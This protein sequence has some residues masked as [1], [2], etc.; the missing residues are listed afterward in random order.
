VVGPRINDPKITANGQYKSSQNSR[1]MILFTINLG[2]RTIM[3]LGK[4]T[5][6]TIECHRAPPT[7]TAGTSNDIK[8]HHLREEMAMV[9]KPNFMV[10]DTG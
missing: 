6:S 10:M 7:A 9:V 1:F 3:Y 5:G 4:S 8:A 2:L